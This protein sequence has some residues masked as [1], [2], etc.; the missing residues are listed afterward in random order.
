[1][2]TGCNVI[3]WTGSWNRRRTW[4]EKRL[5]SGRSLECGEQQ[6]ADR[7]LPFDKDTRTMGDLTLGEAG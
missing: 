5:K 6:C 7:N 3:S 4:V 2:T 1:M